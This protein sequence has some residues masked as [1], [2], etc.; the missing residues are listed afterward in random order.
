MKKTFIITI[1]LALAILFGL[2]LVWPKY[3]AFSNLQ[4]EIEARNKELE[5]K[6]DYFSQ[7]E[8]ISQDLKIY[9][10]QLAKISSA[11]PPD[12]SLPALFNFLQ[13]S[14]SQSGLILEKISLGGIVAQKKDEKPGVIKEIMVNMELSGS[15]ES[16]KNFLSAMEKSA[17]LIEVESISFSSPEEPGDPFSFELSIKTQSY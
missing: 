6:R 12:P 14:A 11:L 2:G 16:F 1:S 15:Y 13:K 9:E 5:S 3:Q 4:A 17:R 8:K 7:V 10:A